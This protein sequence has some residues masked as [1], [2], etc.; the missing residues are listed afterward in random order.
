MAAA[1]KALAIPDDRVFTDVD[2]CIR[3][4]QAGPD[5]PLP[6]DRG[7]RRLRRTGRAVRHRHSGGKTLRGDAR[8]CRPH[9]CRRRQGR[10][11]H[12]DQLAACLV[13]E[14]RHRQAAGRRGR[15][16]PARSRCT[17]TTAIAARSITSPT[18]SRSTP[19]KVAAQK[20]GSWWYKKAFGGGSLLDYLGYGVTLG[21]WYLGGRAPSEVTAVVDQ[22]AG[23]EVDEHSI[24][25][26]RY[27]D[28]LSKFETRW[29]TFTDPWTLQPQP[30][31]GFVLVGTEGTISSYDYEK[32][33]R[34]QTRARPEQHEVPVDEL[35]APRRRPVEYCSTAR[36]PAR[37]SP[38]RSIR[39][40]RG[41]ASASSTPP[42]ARRRRSAL[43]ALPRDRR[44]SGKDHRPGQLRAGRGES[45]GRGR[46]GAALSPAR[47]PGIPAGHRPDRCRR[48]HLRPS[49]CL[50]PGRLSRRRHLQPDL[51]E[52]RRAAR[53]VLPGCR[54]SRPII[55]PCW[56]TR[57]SRSSTSPPIPARVSG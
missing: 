22:P 36:R 50:P 21:T 15:H 4:D 56:R 47:S 3:V 51:G 45:G 34:L 39:S 1:R 31:C 18:R 26:C 53:R 44:C 6:G 12:G 55:A 46:A 42:S 19:E 54:R 49:R 30:K 20:Q 28:G 7:S 52:G 16:R 35:E 13:S 48:H 29:G 40:L 32:T 38:A 8:R 14:P 24:T 2:T 23:L 57:L 41:S 25:I 11:P 27:E 10:H 33:I 9:D 37:R 5:H 17:T 43:W